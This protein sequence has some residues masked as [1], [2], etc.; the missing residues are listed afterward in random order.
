MASD[1]LFQMGAVASNVLFPSPGPADGVRM[2]SRKKKSSPLSKS[3][4]PNI[5]FH[6]DPTYW[7]HAYMP[8]TGTN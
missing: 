6:P 2:L 3:P 7:Y 5:H 1:G 4:F 8:C